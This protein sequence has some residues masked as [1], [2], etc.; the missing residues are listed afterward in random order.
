MSRLLFFIGSLS[1]VAC[2]RGQAPEARAVLEREAACAQSPGRLEVF[3]GSATPSRPYKV[4][5]P[6]AAPRSADLAALKQR[7]CALGAHAVIVTTVHA[8]PTDAKQIEGA[9]M[10]GEPVSVGEAVVYTD[11][12]ADPGVN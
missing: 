12:P 7:A 1:V 3:T 4:I 10:T 5:A 8:L 9:A 11:A 6:V 2:G